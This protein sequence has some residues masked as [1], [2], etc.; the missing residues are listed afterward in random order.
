MFDLAGKSACGRVYDILTK[1][2]ITHGTR[3]ERETRHKTFDVLH[4]HVAHSE[5]FVSGIL[6]ETIA[7]FIRIFFF[8]FLRNIRA[9]Q[10]YIDTRGSKGWQLKTALG[11]SGKHD[12]DN[13]W[14][15]CVTNAAASLC[16][17]YSVSYHYKFYDTV[18]SYDDD[19]PTWPRR[20][21]SF[22]FTT[23]RVRQTKRAL[24]RVRI[25]RQRVFSTTT[26]VALI[27]FLS[28]ESRPNRGEV[29][30]SE[31]YT[32]VYNEFYI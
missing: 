32:E 15:L 1:W 28:D 14:I 6:L 10:C 19:G 2:V 9:L 26:V 7:A 13:R 3:C 25:V 29:E 16:Y 21:N 27:L 20:S 4:A 11:P 23:G 8:C 31:K 12:G 24:V 5:C 18:R 30:M 22:V 17:Y